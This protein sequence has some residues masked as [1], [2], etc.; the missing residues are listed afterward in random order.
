MQNQETNS[1][2]EV[3]ERFRKFRQAIHKAQHELASELNV[4][5]STIANIEGGKAFP[6][7]I[8]LRHFYYKYRL[9]TNWLLTGQGDIFVKRNDTPNKYTELLKFL[10]VPFI[11]QVLMAKLVEAKVLLKDNIDTYFEKKEKKEIS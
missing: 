10:Q 1:R 2:K 4:S 3:G 5:Q 6:N 11:A 8:Y 9:D 7:L